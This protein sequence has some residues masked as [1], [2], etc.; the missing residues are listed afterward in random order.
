M[1]LP[2][3][4]TRN[5]HPVQQPAAVVAAAAPGQTGPAIIGAGVAYAFS[6]AVDVVGAGVASAV[7]SSV[8]LSLVGA[9]VGVGVAFVSD[10]ATTASSLVS[11]R[12]GVM[13][14]DGVGDGVALTAT[15]SSSACIGSS[16]TA[17]VGDGVGEGV[18][19]TAPH[20]VAGAYFPT[21]RSTTVLAA[22]QGPDVTSAS[23]IVHRMEGTCSHQKEPRKSQK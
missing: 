5:P 20:S 19:L 12:V 23:A 7:F 18:A 11:V 14:G 10:S 17:A 16:L 9:G 13:V 22:V 15:A 3:P 4:H 6:V 2:P 21:G 1:A 8:A